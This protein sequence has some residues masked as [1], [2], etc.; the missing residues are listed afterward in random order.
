MRSYSA[1]AA[2][3]FS[4]VLLV[5]FGCGRDAIDRVCHEDSE[6]SG[7]RICI[8]GECL[9]PDDLPDVGEPELPGNDDA[10]AGDVSE[11]DADL[12]DA[13]RPDADAD[14]PDVAQSCEDDRDCP[15]FQRCR[16]QV[17]VDRPECLID[18]DCS[19]QELCIGGVC[20]YSPDCETTADCDS[21]FECVGGQCFE[22][23][24]RGPQDCAEGQF[25]NAGECVDPPRVA[26]CFVASQSAVISRDQLFALQAFALDSEGDGVPATFAWTSSD[27][28]V[29]IIG[30]GGR[31]AIGAG[32]EGTT[33]LTAATQ[34]GIACS[35]EIVLTGQGE[36]PVGDLRVVVIDEETGAGIPGAEVVLH[37][38]ATAI[39]GAGGVAV[40]NAPAGDFAVSVFAADYNYVTVQGLTSSDLRIPLS[41]RRGTGPVAGFTGEFDLSRINSSGDVTLGLAGASIAGGLLDMDLQSLLGETFMTHMEIPTIGGRDMPLPGGLVIYGQVFGLDLDFKRTYYANASGGARIGW[42]LAG[43]VPAMELLGLIQGGGGAGDM[44]TTLL[45]LF[46]RFDHGSRPLNLT[47]MPRVADS[48][49]LDGD[50]DTAEMV[51]DYDAFPVVSLHP[52][53]R[54]TLV[55]DIAVSNFP[56]MSDAAASVAVLV[57]GTLLDGPG[58]VPLGIS[59]TSDEDG[60]GRPDTRRLTV[61]PPHGSLAGGRFAV[62]AIAFEPDQVGF[63]SGVELPDEFSISLWNGQSLPTSVSLGTFPDASAASIDRQSRAVLVS[64]DA[65]PLYRIRMVGADRTWDVWSVGP[66][67]SQG[68][69]S[70]RITIPVATGGR[71]D[72]FASGEIFV[73][74]IAAQ[75]TMDQLVSATGIGLHHAGLVAT[76]FNRTKLR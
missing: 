73:D 27:P 5:S 68:A 54:Q 17:C 70:H 35:G 1:V 76:S 25:C 3:L 44:L 43:K 69:F 37:N 32:G 19:D 65:G 21:G 50:G 62:V 39:T 63:Q 45:P 47:E 64:A 34:A 55:T 16:D 15:A 67:G 38:G 56:Q 49:D 48:Q 7:D 23:I 33:T 2:W 11:G 61:A 60:D 36:V 66:A 51:P 72:L 53:V 12:P 30:P 31:N 57:G 6:C 4:L 71:S 46:S 41:H 24:C 29:A 40:L 10:D 18:S 75:V 59:A 9:N 22:E 8:S 52:S 42:G 26:S 28:S 20:T 58:F 13:D 74:A 14:Q